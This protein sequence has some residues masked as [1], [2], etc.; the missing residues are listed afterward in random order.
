MKIIGN[1]LGQ[2]GDLAMCQV[3][4]QAIKKLYPDCHYSMLFCERYKSCAPLFKN[5]EFIDDL[6]F[7]HGD[8]H[9][10]TRH[11]KNRKILTELDPKILFS[12][13]PQ[14]S[15]QDWWRFFHQTHETCLMHHIPID[16]VSTQ[17]SLNKKALGEIQK[18]ENTVC[19]APFGGGGAKHKSLSLEKTNKI[20]NFL[21][22]KG[23]TVY[24]IGTLNEPKTK[25]INTDL[26]Y[27]DSIKLILS[28]QLLVTVDTGINW[29]T[30][31]YQHPV[32]G[33]YGNEYYGKEYI[34]N[35]QPTNPNAIYL[36]EKNINDISIGLIFEKL[37]EML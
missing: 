25:A 5:N 34:K 11:D 8:Y 36:D 22:K 23:Y 20:I 15:R 35:I 13:F 1:N 26:S 6:I 37:V 9:E 32:L 7:L 2:F 31:G 4:A 27:V 28:S 17:I 12:G 24:K 16:N 18:Q 3:L 10:A 30:S 33:L 19:I 21:Q 29:F 14:H